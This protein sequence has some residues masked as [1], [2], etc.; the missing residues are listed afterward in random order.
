MCGNEVYMYISRLESFGRRA[1]DTHSPSLLFI[2]LCFLF[3]VAPCLAV[4]DR[5]ETLN[6][7]SVVFSH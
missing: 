1:A 4:G 7:V 2:L 6:G 3:T 5:W